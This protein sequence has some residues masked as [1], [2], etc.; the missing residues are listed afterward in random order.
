MLF[1]SVLKVSLFLSEN[2]L[3]SISLEI[4]LVWLTFSIIIPTGKWSVILIGRMKDLVGS[5]LVVVQIWSDS[6]KRRLW[7]E[8]LPFIVHL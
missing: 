3:L 4:L 8:H 2:T 1:K 5:A 6:E 7:L